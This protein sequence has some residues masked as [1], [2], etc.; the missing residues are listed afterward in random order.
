[1]PPPARPTSAAL[2]GW[3]CCAELSSPASVQERHAKRPLPAILRVPLRWQTAAST[4]GRVVHARRLTAA[5]C[6]TPYPAHLLGVAHGLHQLLH[7]HG[8]L[9]REI[10]PLRHQPA[11]VDQDVG[12]RCTGFV[13]AHPRPQRRPDARPC[14][15]HTVCALVHAQLWPRTRDAGHRAGDV[16]VELVHLLSPHAHR[17]RVEQLRS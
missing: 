15:P 3:P 8:L 13:R 16:V 2:A 1:M 14:G 4:H 5:L 17:V 12:V 6:T 10:V 9:V 7:W 11:R